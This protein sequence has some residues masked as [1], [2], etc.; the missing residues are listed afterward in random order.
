MARVTTRTGILK[1]CV[2]VR[3]RFVGQ[4]AVFKGYPV[5]LL[6]DPQRL[7]QV[8]DDVIRQ[9]GVRL[10]AHRVNAAAAAGKRVDPDCIRLIV[11]CSS[12]RRPSPRRSASSPARRSIV[13]PLAAPT[14]GS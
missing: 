10:L 9:V 6:D 8:A 4:R 7:H 5:A 2:V 12:K 13:R 3:R 14:W 1:P 11:F